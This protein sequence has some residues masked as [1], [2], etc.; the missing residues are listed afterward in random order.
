M[1]ISKF[2]YISGT[3]LFVALCKVSNSSVCTAWLRTDA[4][5]ASPIGPATCECFCTD[6]WRRFQQS[7]HVSFCRM[8]FLNLWEM[9]VSF[10][11]VETS[12]LCH[13][14]YQSQS[15][16]MCC[17]KDL[18]RAGGVWL[19]QLIEVALG[20]SLSDLHLFLANLGKS[21]GCK[22]WAFFP[23]NNP[24]PE[25]SWLVYLAKPPP[26]QRSPLEINPYWTHGWVWGSFD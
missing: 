21:L 3:L 11:S 16:N 8:S 25:E 23:S 14:Y 13:F 17:L 24:K 1:K 7:W 5:T 4:R 10:L 18:R 12:I 9:D 15:H 6:P 2:L 19:D 22:T 20:I 26:P